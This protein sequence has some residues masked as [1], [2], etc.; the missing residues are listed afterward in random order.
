MYSVPGTQAN[1]SCAAINVCDKGLMCAD[2][3]FVGAGCLDALG[4]CTPFCKFPG[5]ACPNPDQECVQYFDPMQL[6]E[7]D[8]QLNI[9]VCGI[10][11]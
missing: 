8:P 6:P 2:A 7:N 9:G 3:T 4:C 11:P 5:G 10:P 1:D